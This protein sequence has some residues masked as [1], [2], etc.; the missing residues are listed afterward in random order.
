[1]IT[2]RNGSLFLLFR[3]GNMRISHLLEAHVRAQMVQ[4]VGKLFLFGCLT[5]PMQV[6][7]DEGEII[8]FHQEELKVSFVRTEVDQQDLICLLQ[9]GTQLSGSEDRALLLWP[10]LVAH[11]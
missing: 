11:P 8:H 4:K 3:V 1:V 5:R 2:M 7:T 9:V 10:I 6:T